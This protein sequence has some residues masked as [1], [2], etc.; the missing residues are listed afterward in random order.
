MAN[1]RAPRTVSCAW[2]LALGLSLI[3]V[4]LL[5]GKNTQALGLVDVSSPTNTTLPVNVH[6]SVLTWALEH[7]LQPVPII[8]ETTDGSSSITPSILG[9]GGTVQR[10]FELIPAVEADLSLN[11]IV[12]LATNPS[13][14]W[15]TLDAPVLTSEG[16]VDSSRLATAYPS[17]VDSYAAWSQGLSGAGVGV[18]IVDTGVSSSSHQ[19][20]VTPAGA[21]RV[22]AQVAVNGTATTNTNVTDGYGHGTHVA[23]IVGG[24]G[25]L[26]GGKYIGIAPG[27]N[28]VNVK[29]ANGSG[30]STLADVIAGLEWV[31]DNRDPYNIRVVNLSLHS[32]VA[33]SYQTDPL[34]AAVEVLWFNGIFVAVAAGNLG[35]AS[36]AV[37]YAPANDPFVM[38]VGAIDD[39]GTTRFNDD[40]LA[41]WSS[42]GVTQDGFSKPDLTAPG[43]GIVSIADPKSSLY[44]TSPDKIV[45]HDY[46]R[47]SGTSMAAGVMSGVAALVLEAHPDWTPAELKCALAATARSTSAGIRVASAGSAV[48]QLVAE[49]PLTGGPAPN[50][51]LAPILKVAAVAYALGE[52][53]S[54]AAGMGLDLNALGVPGATLATVDWG[55]IKWNAITWDTIKWSAINWDAIKWSAVKWDA[56]R[57]DLLSPAG[58]EFSAIRWDAIKWS[59]IKWSAIK[60]SAIKWAGS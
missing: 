54:V 57:W 34:D 45:D 11:S 15:I 10:D 19:D 23:G 18:A 6:P 53:E 21:S 16:A 12:S 41:S 8:V 25:S 13:V 44:R 60:W 7:P 42:R 49:C 14:L 3:L 1:S 22:S 9:L 32:T 55:A 51:L 35:A 24:D 26:L 48:N 56:I 59:A 27:A 37:S 52:P 46:L 29:V 36:D 40:L 50:S 30:K 47:L 28:I 20:F 33:Q 38:T 4:T 5:Q 43:R 39:S 31:Y 58:V 2:R 17:A